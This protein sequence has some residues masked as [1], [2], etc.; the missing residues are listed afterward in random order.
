MP[1]LYEHLTNA[2]VLLALTAGL[3]VRQLVK[4]LMFR[5]AL[6]NS[7]PSERAKIIHAM[8]GLIG[9]PPPPDDKDPP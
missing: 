4:L 3:I 8:R 7:R 5:A 9:K 2:W 1:P 6:K